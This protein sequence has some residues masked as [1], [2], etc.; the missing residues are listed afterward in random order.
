MVRWLKDYIEDIKQYLYSVGDY[1]DDRSIIQMIKSELA[2]CGYYTEDGTLIWISPNKEYKFEIT[3]DENRLWS[4]GS[5]Y[6]NRIVIKDGIIGN[7]I[8]ELRFNEFSAVEMLYGIATFPELYPGTYNNSAVLIDRTNPDIDTTVIIE[9]IYGI[10]EY[11][12]SGI[13]IKPNN[14]F[15]Q[16]MENGVQFLFKVQRYSKITETIEDVVALYLTYEELSDL[17]F[18]IFFEC[19]IDIDLPEEYEAELGAVE[20][21]ILFGENK[22]IRSDLVAECIQ[23]RIQKTN[24]QICNNMQ[25]SSTP[26]KIPEKMQYKPNKRITVRINH[27]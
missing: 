24:Y 1:M 23:D 22:Y 14:V 7:P 9:D 4:D 26:T 20:E 19:L 5:H 18:N 25:I 17:V 8:T 21:L 12:N 27:K 16:N 13:Q 10:D 2:T 15:Q 3:R 6:I 11:D